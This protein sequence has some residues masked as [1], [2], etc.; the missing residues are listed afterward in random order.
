MLG[1]GDGTFKQPLTFAP[2]AYYPFL[3]SFTVLDINGDSKPD[4]A[5]TDQYTGELYISFGNSDGPFQPAQTFATGPW[6]AIADMTGDGKLDI[7][8]GNSATHTLAIY[9]G[10]GDGTFAPALTWDVLTPF[11]GFAVADVNGDGRPDLLYA[12][13]SGGTVNVLQSSGQVFTAPTSVVGNLPVVDSVTVPAGASQIT[14]NRDP[15]GT[16][17]DWTTGSLAGKL[18]ISD[19]N[20]LTISADS[21]ATIALNLDYSDGNPLPDTLHLSG[22]FL[23]NNLTGEDPLAGK[24]L[25]IGRSTVLVNYIWPPSPTARILQ[26]LKAGYANGTWAGVATPTSGV[27]TSTAAANSNGLYTL[28]WADSSDG[29]VA[30]QRPQT[31]EVRFTLP[32][33]A[34]LDEAVNSADGV[35][36]ARN[37]LVA[38]KTAWDQGNFNYDSVIDAK[39]AAMLQKNYNAVVISPTSAVVAT[40]SSSSKSA[41]AAVL[42]AA[43][44]QPFCHQPRRQQHERRLEAGH[45]PHRPVYHQ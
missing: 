4:I 21:A 28:G 10:N 36:L 20:G 5:L 15:D 17:I 26:Y 37:Y 42:A 38:G 19:P 32:G 25:E 29:V 45:R 16:E 27:I 22:T 12:D 18:A 8:G 41:P 39:D 6:S 11:Q 13:N 14:L 24:T 30:G 9:P 3:T 43:T 34:N 2:F 35:I 7:V 44:V 1:N 40:T 31:L 23:I 33:D